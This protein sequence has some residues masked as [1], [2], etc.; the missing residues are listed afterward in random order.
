MRALVWTVVRRRLG[1]VTAVLAALLLVGAASAAVSAPTSPLTHSSTFNSSGEAWVVLNDNG[2]A[3][4]A[5]QSSGGNPGGYITA[6]FNPPNF[7]FFESLGSGSGGTWDPGNALGDYGGTLKVDLRATDPT[8]EA[9]YGFFTNN[10]SVLPCNGAGAV[11]TSWG[12]SSMLLEVGDVFD[13]N[14]VMQCT[15]NACVE[16]AKLT[17]PQ[18]SAALAGF[19]QMFV[20]PSDFSGG[21]DTVA[22]D[23]AALS[24][25]VNPVSPST[26]K[27]TRVLTL[28]PYRRGT[29]QGTLVS[30]DDYSCSG[31]AKVS[32]VELRKGKAPLKLGTATSSA[33]NLQKKDGMATFTLKTKAGKGIYEAVVATA[34]SPLDGNTCF[35]AKS[36]SVKVS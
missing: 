20:L 2:L 4:A 14:K 7:G 33:P 23:N 22:L 6:Q 17:G 12:T 28:G 18:V 9:F 1:T 35:A 5:W 3:P 19:R 15:T 30:A 13:C 34:R 11:G 8:S 10:T 27:V 36:K 32:I 21:G 29:F 25:P 16:A 24:A 26:G 31:K